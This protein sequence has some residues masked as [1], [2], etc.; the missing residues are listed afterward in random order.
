M[1]IHRSAV[2]NVLQ[3]ADFRLFSTVV[4]RI[5]IASQIGEREVHLRM[6]FQLFHIH[7]FVAI[8]IQILHVSVNFCIFGVCKKILFGL[9]IGLGFRY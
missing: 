7:H 2:K 4:R 6:G 3:N 8:N 5:F 9:Q 1:S